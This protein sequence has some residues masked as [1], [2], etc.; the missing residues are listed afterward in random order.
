MK[1]TKHIYC[2]PEKGMLDCNTYLIKDEFTLLIDP[3][4]TEFLSVL[5]ADMKQDGIN[6]ED[7]KFIT[8]THLH[9]DHCWA[10]TALKNISGA[11]IISH[12]LHRQ[13]YQTMVPKMQSYFGISDLS[14]ETDSYLENGKLDIGSMVLEVIPLL[15]KPQ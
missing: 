14:F 8:N 9:P 12:P 7:I 10:N 15:P 2:Y 11:K 13:Y 3:G 6:P 4:S 5:L 1:L